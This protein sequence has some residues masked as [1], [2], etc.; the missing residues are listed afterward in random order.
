MQQIPDVVV[1]STEDR[2]LVWTPLRLNLNTAV[3]ARG[4][5]SAPEQAKQ[6][7]ENNRQRDPG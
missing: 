4:Y 2:H 1:Q 3:E 6:S 7:A 5:A